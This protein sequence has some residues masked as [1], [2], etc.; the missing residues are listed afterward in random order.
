MEPVVSIL[1]YLFVVGAG[2]EVALILRAL[3]KLAR[4]RASAAELPATAEE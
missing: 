3:Y 2:I 1:K 4:D